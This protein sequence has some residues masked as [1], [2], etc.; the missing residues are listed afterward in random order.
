MEPTQSQSS[1]EFFVVT[2]EQLDDLVYRTAKPNISLRRAVEK[3]AQ[4]RNGMRVLRKAVWAD[5]TDANDIPVVTEK[6][7]RIAQA[8]QGLV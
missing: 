3:A 6:E 5:W 4:V 1:Q 2:R 7:L 8:V